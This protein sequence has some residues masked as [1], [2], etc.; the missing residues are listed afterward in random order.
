M[1]LYST[2]VRRSELCRLQ[3]S[4]IDSERMMIRIHPAEV[5]DIPV[6]WRLAHVAQSGNEGYGW[7]R[8]D[9]T[10]KGRPVVQGVA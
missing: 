6:T 9:R 8:T 10:I 7:I 4:D 3:V 1:T 2:A 5:E